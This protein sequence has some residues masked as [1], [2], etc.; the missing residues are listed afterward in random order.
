MIGVE[1]SVV[2]ITMPHIILLGAKAPEIN[3]II[4]K[5]V[6]IAGAQADNVKK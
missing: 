6:E 1:M 5:N 3:R 4:P 2:A